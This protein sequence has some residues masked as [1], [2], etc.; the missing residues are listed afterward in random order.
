MCYMSAL[1]TGISQVFFAIDRDEAA[2]YGFDYR[3]TY[4][5]FATDPLN[6]PSLGVSKLPVPDG[7]RPFE[8]FRSGRRP[9]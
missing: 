9:S 6:W 5:L 1:Y 4:A 8:A 7:S 2:A 3:G